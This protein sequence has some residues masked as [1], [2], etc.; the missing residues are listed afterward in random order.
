MSVP[1]KP[2]GKV[3]Y[4][5]LAAL[6][7]ACARM[8]AATAGPILRAFP[9]PIFFSAILAVILGTW[10]HFL[11]FEYVD[12]VLVG[13]ATNTA[14]ETGWLGA[15]LSLAEARA[16]IAATG[17][18]GADLLCYLVYPLQ[19]TFVRDVVSLGGVMG[20]ISIIPPSRIA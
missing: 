14:A 10:A 11:L 13:G 12:N 3:K 8:L 7:V 18:P 4:R 5:G 1:W 19:Y 17:F 15:S 16:G 2:R 9:G 20:F 6:I